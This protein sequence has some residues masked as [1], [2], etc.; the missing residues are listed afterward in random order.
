MPSLGVLTKPDMLTAGATGQRQK[1]HDL[2]AGKDTDPAHSLKLGFY[3][4]KLPE[5]ASRNKN[6]TREQRKREE[7][8][9]FT[10]RAEGKDLRAGN[11]S[12]CGVHNLVQDISK[13]LTEMLG[14]L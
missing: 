6:L 8:D 1:W 13:L 5:D 14:R 7:M 4:V 12:R 9:F 10:L 2:L 11:Q 3:C